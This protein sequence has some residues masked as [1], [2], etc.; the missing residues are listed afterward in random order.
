LSILSLLLNNTSFTLF[1]PDI[2]PPLKMLFSLLKDIGFIENIVYGKFVGVY[3]NADKIDDSIEELEVPK[4]YKEFLFFSVASLITGGDIEFKGINTSYLANSLKILSNFGISYDV[5]EEERIRLWFSDWPK[6]PFSNIKD[7]GASTS[8]VRLFM[9]PVLPKLPEEHLPKSINISLKERKKLIQ[10]L[11]SLGCGLEIPQE[12]TILVKRPGNFRRNN[13][14]LLNNHEEGNYT[15]F[16]GS[17]LPQEGSTL[18][19]VNALLNYNSS[20]LEKLS[21]LGLNFENAS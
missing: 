6:E 3:F 5:F 4:D 10:D 7:V 14:Y 2:N 21:N 12:D 9:L 11:N 20:L 13:L 16:L 18:Y 1:L 19:N 15:R 8:V 17:L